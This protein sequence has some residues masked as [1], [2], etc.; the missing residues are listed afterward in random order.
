MVEIKPPGKL[1][2]SAIHG[3]SLLCACLR[4]HMALPHSAFSVYGS[5]ASHAFAGISSE[6]LWRQTRLEAPHIH[7]LLCICT[8]LYPIIEDNTHKRLCR[9]VAAMYA[10]KFLKW[11]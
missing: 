7:V 6:V 8:M 4:L 10:C 2:S 3:T 9:S 11:Q 5:L 1:N